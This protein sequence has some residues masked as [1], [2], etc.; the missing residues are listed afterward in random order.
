MLPNIISLY[1]ARRFLSTILAMFFGC[2]LLVLLVDFVELIRRGGNKETADIF[3]LFLMSLYRVPELTERILPFATLF[4]SITAFLNLSRRLELVIVRASGMSAWQFMR[5]ALLVAAG[6]GIFAFAV[7]NPAS[8]YLKDLSLEIDAR[9]FGA[10]F[11]MSGQ[12]ASQGWVRQKGEDGDSILKAITSFDNG[13]QLGGV[14]VFSYDKEGNFIERVDA[15]SGRLR[16]GYWALTDVLVSSAS[17]APRQYDS[18]LVSTH[19]TPEEANE[20]IANPNSVPFWELP[21]IINQASRSGLPAHKYRLRYQT[22]LARPLLLAAMVLIAATV[23]LKVFRFGNVGKMILGGV[24]AGFVLYVVTE[25]AKDLGNTGLV[26]PILS[27]WLPAIVASLIG[28]SILL[29]Q[30]DG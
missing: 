26:N 15:R 5:P 21:A 25:L 24:L 10:S 11:S 9:I 29:Y 2:F 17:N 27:A 22:L 28:F 23:S 4:G 8:A 7:Y 30:E 12:T 6:L 18:Y 14:T 3:S 1:I 13:R 19:L 16:S 20:T